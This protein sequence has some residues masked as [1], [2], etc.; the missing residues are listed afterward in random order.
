MKNQKKNQ[1]FGLLL[2]FVLVVFLALLINTTV[3]LVAVYLLE[4]NEVISIIGVPADQMGRLTLLYAAFSVPVGILVTVIAT[5]FPLKPI[6]NLID[7]MDR[8]ASGDFKTRVNVG[9]IMKR[10]PS[11]VVVSESFNKMAEQLENTEMLRSDFINNFSHEFKTPIVSIAGFAKLLRRGNLPPE[12]QQEYLKIIEEESMRLSYMATNVLNLTKVEN[13][14]ILSDIS[15]Y[16]LSEQIRSCILLLEN[17]WGKKDLELQLEF[18][19]H[20]IRA[21]EEQLKQVWINLLDNAIKFAPE[22]HTVQVSITEQGNKLT[23]SV[24]NTGSE[25]AP[26]HQKKIFHKFYQADESHSTQGNGVGLAIVKRITELHGGQVR[27]SS[28]KDVT[29]FTVELPKGM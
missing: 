27:V 22:G 20:T 11:F 24:R 16:N 14:T 25:I 21:N 12:E 17:K 9:P 15:E 1:H 19:E 3:T 4:R 6:R 8:L 26:E 5:K 28:A 23:V 2:M 7:S 18:G 10:Y 29:T 13:Q